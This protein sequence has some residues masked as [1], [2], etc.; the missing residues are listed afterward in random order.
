MPTVEREITVPAEPDEVWEALTDEDLREEWLHDR[1]ADEPRRIVRDEVADD[2]ARELAFRWA[3][4]GED[5][6]EVRF[7]VEAVPAGT[8]VLVRETAPS[9][10]WGPRLHALAGRVPAFA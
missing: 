2:E 8:R 7:L 5:A 3:R 4:P 9:V 10:P 6:T 1:E